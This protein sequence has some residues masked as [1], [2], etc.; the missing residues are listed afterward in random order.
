MTDELIYQSVKKGTELN[1]VIEQTLK[2][3]E[4]Q[5]PDGLFFN[6][7]DGTKRSEIRIK[8]WESPSL[9]NYRNISV[10]PLS[11]LP[12]T[13]IDVTLLKD[14]DYYSENDK[15]VFFGHYW[16]KGKLLLYKDNVCCLD[17]SVAKGGHLVAY[18]FNG[19]LKLDES[20]LTYV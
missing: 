3:K 13:P 4:I 7:K 12:E 17:Y 6:D 5:M 19:E 18:S 20:K 16:L 9:M 2:G 8:W 14:K 1:E 10:E 11:I 15:P